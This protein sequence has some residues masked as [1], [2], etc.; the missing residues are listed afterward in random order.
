MLDNK[1][2]NDSDVL[3]IP[4]PAIPVAEIGAISE[5]MFV[6]PD[7]IEASK[8]EKLLAEATSKE[9]LM[10]HSRKNPM[11]ETCWRS[12]TQMPHHRKKTSDESHCYDAFGDMVTGDYMR[13]TK[14]DN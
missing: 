5:D 14:Q 3:S 8:K 11:R 6:N 7:S 13:L 2:S 9:H 12:I 10:N 4:P 1:S